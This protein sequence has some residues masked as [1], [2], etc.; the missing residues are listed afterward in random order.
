MR[1]H[2]LK[3]SPKDALDKSEED[4]KERCGGQ[5]ITRLYFYLDGDFGG[6]AGFDQI[7]SSLV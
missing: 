4:Q 1:R 3:A 5:F 2:V 7:D 6:L